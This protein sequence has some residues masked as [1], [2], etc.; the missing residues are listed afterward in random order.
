MVSE[1]ARVDL[2]TVWA[3]GLG[4]VALTVLVALYLGNAVATRALR[5]RVAALASL[6]EYTLGRELGSGGMGTVFEATHRAL[7]RRA[8]IKLIHAD[9]VNPE[10]TERFAREAKTT[11]ELTHPNTITLFDYGRTQDGRFYL[12]MEYVEGL[13]FET[14]VKKFG[15]QSEARVR[16]ALVQVCHALTEAHERGVIHRDVKPANLMLCVYGGMHDFVK[17]LDFGLA[18]DEKR[19]DGAISAANLVV[20]TTAYIAPEVLIDPTR[21]GVASDLYAVGCVAYYLLTGKEVFGK[22]SEL[23]AIAAHLTLP[24]PPM[25]SVSDGFERIVQKCLSKKPEDRFVS[26]RQLA[27]A[28]SNLELSPWS[29]VEASDWWADNHIEPAPPSITVRRRVRPAS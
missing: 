8:A 19:H 17:V 6:G 12:V 10:M 7:R 16:H 9:K 15:P 20:G 22:P 14:L 4:S 27:R 23:A 28:L 11:S 26:A 18:K 2:G 5:E 25:P 21:A 3:V 29:E 1:P 13:T 24:P